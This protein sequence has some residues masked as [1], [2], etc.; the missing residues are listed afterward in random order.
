MAH[1]V[2][3][4]QQLD[5]LRGLIYAWDDWQEAVGDWAEQ[6]IDLLRPLVDERS[7]LPDGHCTPTAA[8]FVI[9]DVA[10]N[11][12][13]ESRPEYEPGTD[14]YWVF[15]GGKIDTGETPE[16]AVRRE[17]LE[18]TGCE[19]VGVEQL[20]QP[21]LNPQTGYVVQPYL[22][23]VGDCRPPLQ[24]LDDNRA[25]LSWQDP[26]EVAG[27]ER[28]SARGEIAFRVLEWSDRQVRAQGIV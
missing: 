26:S 11:V 24:S 5:E 15:P 21:F 7:V 13:M 10:G 27:W 16:Q 19:A 12:L 28:R 20:G 22:V 2:I 8:L 4:E 25:P 23:Q 9:R 1:L 17:V 3:S 18:E 6:V 14:P